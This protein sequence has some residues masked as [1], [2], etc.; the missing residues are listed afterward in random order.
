MQQL[1]SEAQLAGPGGTRRIPRFDDLVPIVKAQA[2]PPLVAL[3]GESLERWN[4]SPYV[5][6]V[7]NMAENLEATAATKA[8]E[9]MLENM[10]AEQ[11]RRFD[12]QHGLL[13]DF[14][15]QQ[16]IVV[17]DA[18]SQLQA[19]AEH[20]QTSSNSGN[21]PPAP[22]ANSSATALA[23]LFQNLHGGFEGMIHGQC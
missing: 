22:D 21:P 11:A 9:G 1:I 17:V 2:G 23:P 5:W 16:K 20:M 7:Q 3:R 6:G 18:V 8:D 14:L 10:L 13:R 4:L 12:V 19:P 15:K